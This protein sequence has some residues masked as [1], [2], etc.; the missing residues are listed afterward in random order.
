M[1][2]ADSS[3]LEAM[4]TAWFDARRPAQAHTA[5]QLQ[6][7]WLVWLTVCLL[8]MHARLV[9]AR[10]ALSAEALDDEDQAIAL[11]GQ[12]GWTYDWDAH[13]ELCTLH[14]PDGEVLIVQPGEALRLHVWPFLSWVESRAERALP[15]AVLLR[16]LPTRELLVRAMRVLARPESR[17]LIPHEADDFEFSTSMT[18]FAA[19]CV[20]EEFDAQDVWLRRVEPAPDQHRSAFAAW[21]LEE[22]DECARRRDG[23]LLGSARTRLSDALVRD[24]CLAG[25]EGAVDAYAGRCLEVMHELPGDALDASVRTRVFDFL[26]AASPRKHHPYAPWAAARMLLARRYQS[27]DVLHHVHRFVRIR[28]VKGFKGNP[29]QSK[30][31]EL[32]L[33]FDPDRALDEVRA[34]LRSTTPI[35]AHDMAAMLA[36]LDQDW[37]R[38]ELEFALREA[39]PQQGR[40]E[41]AH[42]MDTSR[43]RHLVA[44]LRLSSDPMARRVAEEFAPGAP[45]SILDGPGYTYD[46]VTHEGVEARMMKRVA[47]FEALAR[48]IRARLADRDGPA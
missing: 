21:L 19:A 41:G 18:R 2:R 32:L 13:D 31:A 4:F 33:E 25:L 46:Q 38:R 24:L 6:E 11:S 16:W 30:W 9:W 39:P 27:D 48:R 3:S 37:T 35:C 34:A 12:A 42:G 44:A 7:P 43:R 26:R 1:P 23:A 45:A 14:G 8:R 10:K 47:K 20:D 40:H 5:S 28:K 29:Y 22:L 36:A 15:E 17:V